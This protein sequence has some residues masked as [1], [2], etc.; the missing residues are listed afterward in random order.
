MLEVLLRV[1]V[2]VDEVCDE[3]RPEL[4]ADVVRR[5]PCDRPVC[6]PRWAPGV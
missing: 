4:V 2:C 1:V 3:V 5:L 6:E